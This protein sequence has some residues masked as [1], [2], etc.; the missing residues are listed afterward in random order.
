MIFEP[1]DRAALAA[2]GLT[3]GT[4]RAELGHVGVLR[5]GREIA[6]ECGHPHTNRDTSSRTGGTSAADCARE[7]VRA[8]RRPRLA[9]SRAAEIAGSWRKLT[10]SRGFAVPSSAIERA[11]AEAPQ[12]AAAYCGRVA[13]VAELLDGKVKTGG[14]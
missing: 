7:L 12:D 1:A 10:S 13:A 9:E 4:R 14:R 11:K 8:A 3:I 2:A 5:R 6:A